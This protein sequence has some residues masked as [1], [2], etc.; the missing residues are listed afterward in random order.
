LLIQE[1]LA[2]LLFSRLR[3]VKATE[4]ATDLLRT[5]DGDL[6][7]LFTATIH[8]LTQVKGIGFVKACKIKAAFELGKRITSY[9]KE[10]HPYY[11]Y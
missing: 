3:K 8:Q 7:D 9:C 2:I 11:L 5:F 6:I 4:I 1:F 10:A